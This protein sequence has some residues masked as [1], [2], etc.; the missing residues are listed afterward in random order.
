[1]SKVGKIIRNPSSGEQFI[2][3]K[4]AEETKG[5]LCIFE[6]TLG[7]HCA[8]PYAHIH[9]RQT[10]TFEVLGGELSLMINGEDVLVKVGET[11][12]VPMGAVHQPRNRSE[13]EVRAYMTFRPALHI[14]TR[15]EIICGLATDGIVNGK[16]SPS[17]WQLAVLER[18]YPNMTYLAFTSIR[19]QRVLLRAGAIVGRLLG[20]KPYYP[21]YCDL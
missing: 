2:F 18:A 15:L 13:K 21:K 20:Y 3:R 16:G 12:T 19:R 8:V 1:M 5:E 17:F 14:E 11:V 7:P 10:E 4:T 6:W 9:P